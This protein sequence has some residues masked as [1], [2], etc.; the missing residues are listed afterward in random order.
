LRFLL[1]LAAPVEP[2]DGP[3]IGL[4]EKGNMNPLKHPRSIACWAPLAAA[5][6][7]SATLASSAA[8]QAPAPAPPVP[9]VGIGANTSEVTAEEFNPGTVTVQRNGALLNT[10]TFVDST[11]PGRTIFTVNSAEIAGL[12]LPVGCWGGFTPQ[13]LPGDVVTVGT[14]APVTIPNLSVEQPVLQGDTVVVHGTASNIPAG[15]G[16]SAQI[17]P[18]GG[19]KFA[20][21]VG[22]SGGAFLDTGVPKGFPTSSAPARCSPSTGRPTPSRPARPTAPPM[23]PTRRARSAAR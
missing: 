6:L 17:F 16:V 18:A 7:G 22:S 23:R 3:R 19:G 4:H 11:E 15:W 21:G 20:G 8:A 14:E 5:L 2:E 13:I 10:G 9:F 12:G 1:S